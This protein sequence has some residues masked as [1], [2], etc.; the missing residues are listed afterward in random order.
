M[1][2][3]KMVAIS[4]TD[5]PVLPLP[6]RQLGLPVLLGFHETTSHV[7]KW[8]WSISNVSD[9]IYS[10]LGPPLRDSMQY[11]GCPHPQKLN[12]QVDGVTM[13]TCATLQWATHAS[14]TQF[15]PNTRNLTHTHLTHK[16]T[17]IGQHICLQWLKMFFLIF[18]IDVSDFVILAG[19][20]DGSL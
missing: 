5:S 8:L 15:L 12:R 9:I 1:F 16:Q 7:Y 6:M 10:A 3:H 2:L 19:S 20:R 4:Y 14:F 13:W 17:H 18:D 11:H